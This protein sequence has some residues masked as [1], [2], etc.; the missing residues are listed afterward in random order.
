[1]DFQPHRQ[2]VGNLRGSIGLNLLIVE[3]NLAAF[4]SIAARFS[5]YTDW[6]LLTFR[7]N[8]QEM[9]GKI[10]WDNSDLLRLNMVLGVAS[11]GRAANL[12]GT[13]ERCEG[14]V[15]TGDPRHRGFSLLAASHGGTL[16]RYVFGCTKEQFSDAHQAAVCGVMRGWSLPLP[17][18]VHRLVLKSDAR[19]LK[20]ARTFFVYYNRAAANN[21]MLSDLCL[22]K[23]WRVFPVYTG[24]LPRSENVQLVASCETQLP[25]FSSVYAKSARIEIR[26]VKQAIL[27]LLTCDQDS[28]ASALAQV[29][30]DVVSLSDVVRAKDHFDLE[31]HLLKW[32]DGT[33]N[34]IHPVIVVKQ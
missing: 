20:K 18:Q 6:N 29:S 34:E 22:G 10:P 12:Q 13:R 15:E 2:L 9:F 17:P 1:M 26:R 27:Q 21:A 23:E 32:S 8:S 14:V 7:L 30:A 28:G 16:P 11:R 24:R 5:G 3:D 19:R 4:Q 33:S 25:I 31:I